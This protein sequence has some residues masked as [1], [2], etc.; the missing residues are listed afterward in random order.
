MG[1]SLAGN[2][3]LELGNYNPNLSA[4]TF[5]FTNKV[6]ANTLGSLRLSAP[7]AGTDPLVMVCASPNALSPGPVVI[8]GGILKLNGYSYAISNLS[9]TGIGGL[10]L[11]GSA[12]TA[13][14]LTVGLDNNNTSFGG[15][16]GNGDAA[17]LGLTKVG[18]GTF[19]LTA[20]NTNT[21]PTAVNGGTLA[22]SGSGALASPSILVGSAGI[23][24]V[25]GL[26]SPP[27]VLATNQALGN[28]SSTAT[29]NGSVDASAGQ[30]S[31]TY[32]AGIP[33][34]AV[35]NG[36]LTLAAGTTFSINNTGT[37]LTNGSY[38]V[39][40]T[41]A[42]GAVVGAVPAVVTIGGG[43]L[44]TGGSAALSL[45]DSQL[46]LN[47]TGV[48]AVATNSPV[49]TNSI[50]GHTL[51]L[52]WP[53]DHLGW[54]LQVQTNTLSSGLG[55]NWFTWPNSTNLTSV[56]IIMDPENPATFFRLVYP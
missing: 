4:V 3:E 18:T 21:G 24:D 17:T 51:T 52:S 13:S 34:L 22:L 11:N 37:A 45:A 28:S 46:Y 2:Y 38:L 35:T 6:T 32:A 42:G 10:V 25:S 29:V 44:G 12:T 40:S 49:L 1:G 20:V 41:N 14:T 5:T 16:L 36:N 48:I 54:R 47:V 15:V 43:G 26:S 9:D 55:T 30:I 23:F 27:L 31:L 33:A 39:I 8:N 19:T 50:S 7:N 53:A 56:P